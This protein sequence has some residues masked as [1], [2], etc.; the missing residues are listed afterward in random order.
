MAVADELVQLTIQRSKIAADAAHVLDFAVPPGVGGGDGPPRITKASC[1][2]V[3]ETILLDVVPWCSY[4]K[5]CD[6]SST[7]PKT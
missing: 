5:A 2:G 4:T 3:A 7:Q 1:L 6:S